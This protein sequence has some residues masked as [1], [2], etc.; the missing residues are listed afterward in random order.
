MFY[1]CDKKEIEN[2]KQKIKELEMLKEQFSAIN[3]IKAVLAE[4]KTTNEQQSTEIIKAIT[5]NDKT[6]PNQNLF[7]EFKWIFFIFVMSFLLIGVYFIGV[8][9]EFIG[10]M[11]ILGAF[12]IAY[13]SAMLINSKQ[14]SGLNV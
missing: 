3:D 10:C 4:I 7:V 12:I 1:N 5:Q 11:S 14:S 13:C 2:L 9:K 8:Q 6:D